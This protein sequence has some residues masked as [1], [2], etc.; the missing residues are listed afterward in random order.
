MYTVKGQDQKDYGPVN[1]EQI[2]LWLAQGRVDAGTF[3][4][5][6]GAADWRPLASFPELAVAA[7]P[8]PLTAPAAPQLD[9]PFATIVPYRNAPAL[10]A[11][12]L[13]V[14]SLIPCV[15]MALGIGAVILGIIGLKQASKHPEAK[16]KVHAWIG[17]ILGSLVLI[18]HLVF[19]IIIMVH[20]S[21]ARG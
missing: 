17:I 19:I 11:Y 1:A 12:Y 14:F 13:G 6:E 18:A 2:R 20:S 4:R 7:A 3:V 5:A 15:G 10:I 9:N 21:R 8:P 16:G